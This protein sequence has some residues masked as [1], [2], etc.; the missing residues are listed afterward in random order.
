MEATPYEEGGGEVSAQAVA[1]ALKQL[2]SAWQIRGQSPTKDLGQDAADK[3]TE[4][5]VVEFSV[6]F[7]FRGLLMERAA[8]AAFSVVA[9]RLA[10]AFARRAEQLRLVKALEE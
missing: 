3:S 7:S 1:G 8:E 6:A 2:D 10:Q 4:T 9:A 5:S